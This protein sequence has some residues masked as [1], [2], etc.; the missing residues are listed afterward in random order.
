MA[1]LSFHIPLGTITLSEDDGHIVS[2]DEG[3][4]RDQTETPLLVKARTLLQDY[5]DGV[6]VDL[7]SLPVRPYGTDYQK[8]VWEEVRH[9]PF[10]QTRRYGDIAHAIG[11]SAQSVG[12]ALGVNMIP[13]LI[14]CHRVVSARGPGAYSAFGGAEDK[15]R[16]LD[17]ESGF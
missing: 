5:F 15:V 11:G 9:I 14:P 12:T 3:W 7:S 16:L 10:G 6:S 4:G 8:R 13:L 1:Q 17:L 2:L